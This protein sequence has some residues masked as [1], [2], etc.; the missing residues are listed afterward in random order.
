MVCCDCFEHA[1]HLVTLGSLKVADQ[2]LQ[3]HFHSQG[4][5]KQ[6][7]WK[8]FSSLATTSITI[9]DSNKE[10]FKVWCDIHGDE[11]GVKL[12]KT[13]RPKCLAGRWNSCNDVE[14]RMRACGG[15]EFVLPVLQRVLSGRALPAAKSCGDNVDEIAVEET[16][17]RMQQMGRWRKST[18]NCVADPLWWTVAEAMR[19]ARLPSLH[20]SASRLADW[21]AAS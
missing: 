15:Q 19:I 20:L 11:S 1:A 16:A 7:C 8:Y 18:S 13:L 17:H 14:S 4:R 3:G 10:F 5:Q 21:P 12:A 6:Q 9:R 2:L